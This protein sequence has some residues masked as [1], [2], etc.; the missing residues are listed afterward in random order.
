VEDAVSAQFSGRI[1]AFSKPYFER[2]RRTRH[3]A[4]YFDPGAAP[5]TE[6]DAAW[7]IEKATDALSAARELLAESALDVFV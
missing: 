6:P 4:Q 7:A 3:S 2:F 5:I 1:H